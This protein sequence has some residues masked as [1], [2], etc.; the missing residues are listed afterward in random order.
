MTSFP[1]FSTEPDGLDDSDSG[2]AQPTTTSNGTNGAT[3]GS[4]GIVVHPER[5]LE[6]SASLPAGS[7]V[8]PIS[9]EASQYRQTT[10]G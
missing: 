8:A 2:Q 9:R 7:P 4:G 6:R 3:N 10:F 5:F 1:Q